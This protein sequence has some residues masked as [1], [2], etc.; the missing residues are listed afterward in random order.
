M[1]LTMTDCR[2]S[3]RTSARDVIAAQL[4]NKHPPS[5][6]SLRRAERMIESLEVHGYTV[7]DA[8]EDAVTDGE[9]EDR[10]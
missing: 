3:W 2:T 10:K 7:I 8:V 6:A 4:S 5:M 9:T 1:A